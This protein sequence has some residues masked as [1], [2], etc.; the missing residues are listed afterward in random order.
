[1]GIKM[2]VAGSLEDHAVLKYALSSM[3]PDAQ[4]EAGTDGYRALE[5]AL[6]THPDLIVVDPTVP[7]I[8]GPE[9]IAKLREAAPDAAIV[10]WTGHAD[11]DQAT[12]L[13]RA[14]ASGYLLKE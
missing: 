14:G 10:C 5:L 4:V 8:S 2:V 11:V 3:M 7:E 13:L 1:M 12:E 9:L 6:R